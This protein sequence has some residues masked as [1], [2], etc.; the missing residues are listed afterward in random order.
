[1]ISTSYKFLKNPLVAILAFVVLQ[2]TLSGFL[3]YQ[4]SHLTGF[5]Q[6]IYRFPRLSILVREIRGQFVSTLV[7]FLCVYLLSKLL[8][9]TNLKTIGLTG[10]LS[11]AYLTAGFAAQV[12]IAVILALLVDR[13][14][15]IF[16]MLRT[17]SRVLTFEVF[18]WCLL[19]GITEETIF[20]GYIL[21]VLERRWGSAIALLLSSILFGLAHLQNPGETALEVVVIG[22]TGGLPYAAAYLMTRSLWLPI[23]LHCGWDFVADLL[24]GGRG[25]PSAVPQVP[26][27]VDLQNLNA[28]LQIVPTLVFVL[29]AMR[30]GRWVGKNP[31]APAKLLAANAPT[32]SAE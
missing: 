29:I 17:Y 5:L 18:V 15:Q 2:E 12:A 22:L 31:L 14:G 8:P 7:T 3:I 27:L 11:L 1:M 19:I 21:Q 4:A 20:R 32:S 10:R 24:F 26:S 28:A 16:T 9:R 23:G 6:T 30:T 25:V 13:H